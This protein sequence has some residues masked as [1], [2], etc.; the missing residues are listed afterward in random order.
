MADIIFLNNKRNAALTQDEAALKARKRLAVHT[1]LKFTGRSSRC[2][3]CGDTV[4]APPAESGPSVPRRIPYHF[5]EGCAA[6]YKDYI[7]RLK[8]ESTVE[9]SWQTDTWFETWTQWIGY[10]SVMDRYLKSKA[11]RQLLEEIKQDAPE[12]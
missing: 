7:Q 12:K 4:A 2:E 5:C 3:R 1:L 6:D 8:G 11:F 9:R 10:Q